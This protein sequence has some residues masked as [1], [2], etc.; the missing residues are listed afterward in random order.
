MTDIPIPQLSENITSGT[1][2]D[3]HV[4]PGDPV[5]KG[6]LLL[7]LETDKATLEIP[8]P[9]DGVISEVLTGKGAVVNV[10]EVVLRAAFACSCGS[11]ER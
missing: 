6:Q 10:G 2:I 3:I 9:V 1:V 7:E 8:S 5:K 4:K 11:C